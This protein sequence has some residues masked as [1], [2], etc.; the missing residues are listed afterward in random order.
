MP[1]LGKTSVEKNEML[2]ENIRKHWEIYLALPHHHI[3]SQNQVK[4]GWLV[5]ALAFTSNNF[6]KCVSKSCNCWAPLPN[7]VL[8]TH[9][10]PY[11]GSFEPRL[12][13]VHGILP[14]KIQFWVSSAI[15][16]TQSICL[17]TYLPNYPP[18]VPSNHLSIYRSTALVDLFHFFSFLSVH[19]W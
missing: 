19:T 10:L 17:P 13:Y 3:P 4:K 14:I 8:G 15:K 12:F 9:T 16:S 5:T 2:A 7:F 6:S 1:I 18:T 11:G